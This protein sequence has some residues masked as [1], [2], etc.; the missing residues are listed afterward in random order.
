MKK[1]SCMIGALLLPAAAGFEMGLRYGG[2][3]VGALFL[4]V[5]WVANAQPQ[6]GAGPPPPGP[7]HRHPPVPLI[8]K[9]LDTNGDG[10]IDANE[11]ANAT[12]ALK[13]LDKNGDGRLTV[14][15][16]IG[17]WAS[18]TNGP[19]SNSQG[20]RPPLPPVVKV[21]DTNGDGI[22]DAN[23]MSNA[24]A[25]LKTLDKNGDG[26]LTPDEYLP[27]RPPFRD[28]AFD[29]GPPGG[30][31]PGPPPDGAPPPDAPPPGDPPP[32]GPPPK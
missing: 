3:F 9:A 21:L 4:L 22:I 8:I 6:D 32:D 16:Y 5:A 28:G 14:E 30:P 1:I 31:P 19:A 29:E 27:P 11:I 10:I 23:E 2:G 15:E 17:P 20:R 26:Q 24:P 7:W 18:R 12:A 13:T 25:A